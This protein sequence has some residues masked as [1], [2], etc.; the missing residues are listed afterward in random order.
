MS[1]KGSCGPGEEGFKLS[2]M[3][4]RDVHSKPSSMEMTVDGKTADLKG[5]AHM[6]GT[7]NL[8]DSSKTKSLR[9]SYE[10]L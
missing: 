10:G 6:Q 9:H 1:F 8:R 5:M 3:G 7:I 2:P 4:E